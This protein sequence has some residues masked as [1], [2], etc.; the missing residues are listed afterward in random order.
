MAPR[1]ELQAL[2]KSLLGNDNVYFQPP[3]NLTMQYDCVRYELSDL[4]VERANNTAYTLEK[5]YSVTYIT[6]NADSDFPVRFVSL[7]KCDF[8]RAYRADNL[9]HHVFN[10]FF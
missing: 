3:T 6:R 10:I 9:Y 4:D 5:K 2:L 8:E 1:L 7:P